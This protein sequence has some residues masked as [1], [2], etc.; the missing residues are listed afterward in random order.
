MIIVQKRRRGVII[1]LDGEIMFFGNASLIPSGWTIDTNMN[2]R[3]VQGGTS[4]SNTVLGTSTHNHTVPTTG[5]AS[6]HSHGRTGS[7]SA[8]T[9]GEGRRATDPIHQNYNTR[10]HTHA[11]TGNAVSGATPAHT[12]S[13]TNS[14]DTHPAWR[15][16]YWIRAQSNRP[17][18][19]GGVIMW[20]GLIANIPN[21]YALCN[22][23]NGTPDLRNRFVRGAANDADVNATG[24]ANSHS[25]TNPNTGSV[26][27]HTHTQS[28]GTGTASGSYEGP[29]IHD[30]YI[31][32]GSHSHTIADF[33]T[34]AGGAHS[35]TLGS[36]G[37]SDGRPPF[38]M[39]YYIMRIA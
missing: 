38:M 26:A 22:G 32:R 9:M 25:H 30:R 24:G 6:D 11:L 36:S 34:N 8:T 3:F 13:N 7:V 10:T 16:L 12:T 28:A 14:A 29:V 37:S 18:P 5:T 21:N 2:S 31:S 19:V 27:D 17:V 1:P 39:L 33:T 20:D 23:S 35:H 15:A 4:S